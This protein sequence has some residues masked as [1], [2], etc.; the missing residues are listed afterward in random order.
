MNAQSPAV[1]NTA[2]PNATPDDKTVVGQPAQKPEAQ[3]KIE[4]KPEAAPAAKS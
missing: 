3:P 4:P 1:T 2:V